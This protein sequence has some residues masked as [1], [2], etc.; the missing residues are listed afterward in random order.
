MGHKFGPQPAEHLAAIIIG[1]PSLTGKP[2]GSNR[3]Y[4]ANDPR[5]NTG[6]AA[7]Y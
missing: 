3:F 2:V 5:L 7:G 1:A 4:G 6:L